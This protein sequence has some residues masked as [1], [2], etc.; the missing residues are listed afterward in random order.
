MNK[1]MVGMGVAGLVA[2]LSACDVS[3]TVPDL[4]SS[5]TLK[6]TGVTS[7]TSQYQLQT[8]VQDQNGA[9]LAAGTYIICDD[10]NT[11]LT[12]GVG[13]SGPLQRIG[14]RFVGLTN[15]TTSSIAYG[16]NFSTPNYSGS[17]SATVTFGAASAPLSVSSGL[18]AQAIVVTPVT[19][20]Q[21]NGYTYVQAFGQDDL[22]NYSNTV[23]SATAIPVA[24]RCS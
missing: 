8:D 3:V 11:Q 4:G 1:T 12:V 24:N 14:I 17:G 13:W 18:K 15:G 19:N 9:S 6:L 23:Q 21:I 5:S 10:R 2:L 7:Y 20:V 16:N 22:G